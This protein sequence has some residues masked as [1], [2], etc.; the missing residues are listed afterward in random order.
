MSRPP[1]EPGDPLAEPNPRPMPAAGG[2]H[3]EEYDAARAY[4]LTRA[5]RTG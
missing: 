3:T 2:R 4:F 1:P 5:V